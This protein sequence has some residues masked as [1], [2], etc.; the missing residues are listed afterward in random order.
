MERDDFERKLSEWLDKP[1]CD[2]LRAMID[3]A[4]AQ[5]PR[6]RPLRADWQRL[7]DLVKS[8]GAAPEGV[9]WQRLRQSIL[10]AVLDADEGS[11]RPMS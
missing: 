1:Q 11:P 6:L 8:S 3:R 2:K 4:V 7:N 10:E 5:S 9:E